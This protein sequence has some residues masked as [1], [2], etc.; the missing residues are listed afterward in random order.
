MKI[1]KK[2]NTFNLKDNS[3]ARSIH[4]IDQFIVEKGCLTFKFLWF[5]ICNHVYVS[6]GGN[7]KSYIHCVVINS[8]WDEETPF[9]RKNL[10]AKSWMGI[11]LLFPPT[12]FYLANFNDMYRVKFSPSRVI[13][14]FEQLQVWIFPSGTGIAC[15][16]N[17]WSFLASESSDPFICDRY[18]RSRGTMRGW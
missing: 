5:S 12:H 2:N 11:G 16:F 4:D 10:R 14:R 9:Y 3:L 17:I 18:V 13:L 8:V 7:T 6:I 1:G 15:F